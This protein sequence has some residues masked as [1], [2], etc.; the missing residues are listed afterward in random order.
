MPDSA[1]F[2]RAAR[3]ELA[4]P[5]DVREEAQRLLADPRAHQVVR[6]FHANVFGLSGLDYLSKNTQSFPQFT[7][8]LGPLLRREGETFLEHA[9]WE[10]DGKL[11][12]LL[13][14]GYT[15]MNAPLA[16]FYGVSGPTGDAFERVELDTTQRAGILTQAGLMAALTPGAS[17]N[18][19][20]RGAYLRSRLF[21]DPPPDPPPNLNVEEPRADPELTTR[22][23]FARHRTDSAC[24]GC[25]TLLDPLGLPFENFDGLGQWR[26]TE[27]GKPIDAS[28]DL[29]GTDVAGPL[30]GGVEVARRI[31]QSTQARDC[32]ANQWLSF[33]Y[34]RGFAPQDACTRRSVE[35]TFAATDG[36]ILEL[37][38]ELTQT[39]AFLY[40]TE[41]AP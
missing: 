28:G 21:C 40:R 4:S 39:D 20:L 1:L 30:V 38:L 12:T 31:A 27:N 36:S 35:Q 17:T 5:A 37:L 32:Y 26:D 24:S 19:V 41:E 11:S 33:A 2:E 25:H 7:P 6:F 23:R 3:G 10:D 22:E 18:P 14:A 8:Q 15:F 29:V 13:S 9:V 34:G 16:A